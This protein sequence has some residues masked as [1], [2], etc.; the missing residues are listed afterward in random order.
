MLLQM[1][2]FFMSSSDC[3]RSKIPAPH[4]RNS[5][6][7]PD[8]SLV[9]VDTPVWGGHCESKGS[10]PGGSQFTAHFIADLH[11]NVFF[12]YEIVTSFFI[13][14]S[15]TSPCNFSENLLTGKCS[16]ERKT[17][18]GGNSPF[19]EYQASPRS[20]NCCGELD[21][22]RRSRFCGKT[23]GFFRPVFPVRPA[24]LAL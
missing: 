14:F 8:V 10:C 11:F 22:G 7:S 18:S 5:S 23:P 13:Y 16:S 4:P 12:L 21:W 2:P 24:A 3:H 20:V 1:I 6:S 17:S 19:R 9:T 15:S